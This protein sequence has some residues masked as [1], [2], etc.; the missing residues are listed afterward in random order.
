MADKA[1]TVVV[2]GAD[3]VRPFIEFLKDVKTR[4]RQDYE[5]WIAGVETMARTGWPGDLILGRNGLRCLCFSQTFAVTYALSIPPSP[6]EIILCV[7]GWGIKPTE[8]DLLAG[9]KT[10][11][12]HMNSKTGT[13]QRKAVYEPS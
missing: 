5:E 4:S 8:T 3:S 1:A 7:L 10:I 11:E 13:N 9:Q 12:H 6:L 2:A